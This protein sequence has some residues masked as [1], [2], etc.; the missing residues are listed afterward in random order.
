M[1]FL[2][3]NVFFYNPIINRKGRGKPAAGRLKAMNT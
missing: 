3:N 1:Q 2:N